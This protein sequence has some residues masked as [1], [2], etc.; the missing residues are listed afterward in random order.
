[1]PTSARKSSVGA[2]R[3][4]PHKYIPYRADDLQ[5]GKKTGIV[6]EYVDH[7][8]D[9]F[10]PFDKV[11]SQADQRTPPRVHARK[12]RTPKPKTPRTPAVQ[13]VDED[14]EKSMELEHSEWFGCSSCASGWLAC[15]SSSSHGR[16]CLGLPN[17]PSAYFRN[18]RMTTITS[19]VQRVGS[20]SRPVAHS[21]DVDFE[22]V[23]SPRE[24]PMLSHRRSLAQPRNS[25]P[26]H[27]SQSTV[28]QDDSDDEPAGYDGPDFGAGGFDSDDDGPPAQ[29]FLQ[30]QQHSQRRSSAHTSRRTSFAQMDQDEEERSEPMSDNEDTPRAKGK[31]RADISEPDLEPDFVH[32][33]AHVDQEQTISG[34]VPLRKRTGQD[35]DD[36]NSTEKYQRPNKKAKTENEGAKKP[37]GR[38]KGSKNNVLRDGLSTRHRW[39]GWLFIFSV[40]VTP[41]DENTDGLRRGRRLRY[42]PLEWWRCEKVVYGRRE[43]GTS[44][45]PTIKEIHR[46]PKEEPQPLGA[47]HRRKRPPRSQSKAGDD[48]QGALVYNPEEGWD[49]DTQAE[50]PII[51]W[52]SKDEVLKRMYSVISRDTFDIKCVMKVSRL[53]QRWSLRR[54]RPIKTSTSRR[55]LAMPTLSP[56]ASSSYPRMDKS[57]RRVPRTTHSYARLVLT[58]QSTSSRHIYRCFMSSRARSTS[59][60]TGQALS[61]RRAACS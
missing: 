39:L 1:M 46:I 12:R 41:N 18:A 45:V 37:R 60:Y 47:K 2:A 44:Y 19:S 61:W 34:Y 38:P 31:E 23:P 25:G 4:A 5:H 13:E 27:L 33:L 43:S 58:S 11:M 21:S 20:S 24:S 54:L 35:R 51:D 26:S 15:P 55:S 14:G 7:R 52:R 29:S 16:I 53:P 59:L 49:E 50:A 40:P 3:R 32:S 6:V 8:S 10:E 56:R 36:D 28:A 22:N 17:S 42:K 48:A 9:E 57:L 30:S